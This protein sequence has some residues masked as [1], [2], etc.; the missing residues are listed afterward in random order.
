M[1]EHEVKEKMLG[2]ENWIAIPKGAEDY[3]S[4][5]KFYKDSGVQFYSYAGEWLLSEQ[6]G[7]HQIYGNALPKH[8]LYWV[9]CRLLP[10]G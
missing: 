10:H 5:N 6:S 8:L 4:N 7:R 9:V 2:H 3:R 1:A